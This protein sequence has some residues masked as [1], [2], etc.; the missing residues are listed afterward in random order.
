MEV[1]AFNVRD[2]GPRKDEVKFWE[3]KHEKCKEEKR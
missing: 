2:I 1:Q 3:K